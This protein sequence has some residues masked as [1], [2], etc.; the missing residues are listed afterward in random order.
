MDKKWVF[1]IVTFLIGFMLAIQ[2]QSTNEPEIR[3]TRDIRE[4][5]NE[6]I[7]EREKRQQLTIEIH[8]AERLIEK[9]KEL[10]ENR[11]DD[12]I[13]VLNEQIAELRI[14]AGL[15]E[16]TGKGLL[17]TIEALENGAFIGFERRIPPPDVFRHLVNELNIYGA[18]HIAI[19]DERIIAISAFRDVN[20]VTY[21]NSRRLPPPPIE[22]KVLTDDPEKLQNHMIVSDAV[23]YFEINGF[24]L[25]FEIKNNLT[26]P[27]YG[28]T[29]RV[30]FM[31][32]VEEG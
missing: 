26:L 8:K 17:V 6:L 10:I 20:E 21:L 1:T 27:A 4:L 24:S 30:R 28:Q 13:N 12:V 25:S 23:E 9:Y 18:E 16:I 14:E 31:E 11:D 22:V 29:P 5:R 3:D 7:A 32:K 19:E 2:F 15:E